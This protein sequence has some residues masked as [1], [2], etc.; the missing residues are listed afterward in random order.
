MRSDRSKQLRCLQLY[1][2]YRFT[3]YERG[4]LVF[5][6]TYLHRN[7]FIKNL[8]V[9]G[10]FHEALVGEIIVSLFNLEKKSNDQT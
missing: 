10:H 1:F 4:P 2:Q 5:T 6:A 7:H 3:E 8:N 9:F